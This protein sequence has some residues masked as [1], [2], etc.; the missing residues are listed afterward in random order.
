MFVQRWSHQLRK[1]GYVGGVANLV[2][3]L[4]V[5]EMMWFCLTPEFSTILAALVEKSNATT[6]SLCPCLSIYMCFLL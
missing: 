3:E 5:P 1:G 4:G 6:I 2:S